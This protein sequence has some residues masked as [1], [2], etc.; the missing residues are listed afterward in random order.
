MSL[1]E[2]IN[3]TLLNTIQQLMCQFDSSVDLD[4]LSAVAEGCSKVY[5]IYKRVPLASL[6]TVYRHLKNL[7]ERGYVIQEEKDY[8]LTFKGLLV[9]TFWGN[10]RALRSIHEAYPELSKEDILN[11]VK[12]FCR[13]V[14]RLDFL[15]VHN[16][17]DTL[18]LLV[19]DFRELVKFKGTEVENAIAKLCVR[20]CPSLKVEDLQAV[21]SFDGERT[22]CV[23]CVDSNGGRLFPEDGTHKLLRAFHHLEK[24]LYK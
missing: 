11:Y 20:K 7:E 14:R 13:E 19:H 2:F 10:T 16:L 22:T 3:R 17:E 15:P 6:A 8:K 21:L 9:L 1:S 24:M 18:F 23:A 4:I 12:L 5:S